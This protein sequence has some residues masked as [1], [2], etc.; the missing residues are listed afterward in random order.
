MRAKKPVDTRYHVVR[1][2]SHKLRVG[3]TLAV[4]MEREGLWSAIIDA[5]SLGPGPKGVIAPDGSMSR[6]GDDLQRIPVC[7]A[8]CTVAGGIATVRE[9]K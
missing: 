5:K 4:E 1:L 9:V 8:S 7:N 2:P 6:T 3:E